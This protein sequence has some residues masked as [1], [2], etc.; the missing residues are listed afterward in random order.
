MR[1][2]TGRTNLFLKLYDELSIQGDAKLKLVKARSLEI[3]GSLEF[4]SLDVAG[5]ADVKGSVKGTK[6]KFGQLN[7][8]APWKWIMLF[9]TS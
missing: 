9:V 6:G 3:T 5:K 8:M 1:L 4:Q 7:G 2:L